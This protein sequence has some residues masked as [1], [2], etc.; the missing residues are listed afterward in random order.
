MVSLGQ[1]GRDFPAR[2]RTTNIM[3]ELDPSA[4]IG[5]T[6]YKEVKRQMLRALAGGE[7]NPGE[8]IPAEKRLCERFA[9]S[10]GTLRKAIDELAAENILI[11]HQGRGT[12][13]ATHNREQQSFRFFNV[14]AHDGDKSYPVLELIGFEKKKPDPLTAEKLGLVGNNAKVFEFTNV[15]SLHGEPVIVDDITL[16]EALFPRLTEAQIRNRS[17]TLYNLY[18]SSFGVNVIRTDERL[19]AATATAAQAKL[20]GIKTGAP[21]LEVR[22]VAYSYNR[23]PVEWRISHVNTAKHEYVVPS[24]Q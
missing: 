5:T 7:W 14:V 12:F 20:L 9:V 18:Q 15:L 2:L 17:N 22:R 24:A 11:R 23:Q 10:I 1:L 13:V 4:V 3:S 16:P 21:L 6:L 8:A 19:R